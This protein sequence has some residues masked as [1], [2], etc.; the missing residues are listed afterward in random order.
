[1]IPKYKNILIRLIIIGVLLIVAINFLVAQTIN[2]VYRYESTSIIPELLDKYPDLVNRK[3]IKH[4][5]L[6]ISNNISRYRV[7]SFNV[8]HMPIHSKMYFS[9]SSLYKDYQKDII[10]K[11]SGEYKANYAEQISMKDIRENDFHKWKITNDT[12]IR[13]GVSCVK[14]IFENAN[15]A[16]IRNV[17]S[18]RIRWI[19]V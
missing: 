8:S 18:K 13:C 5:S 12:M 7:D 1:M 14:A 2:V 3:V 17:Y 19:L 4:S 11:F 15:G 9:P 10:V 6:L 16:F